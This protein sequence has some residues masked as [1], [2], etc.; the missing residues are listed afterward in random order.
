[1]TT[2]RTTIP[3]ED[4]FLSKHIV[5][6]LFAIFGGACLALILIVFL[7]GNYFTGDITT[8][9]ERWGTFGDFVGGALNPVIG[10][11]GLL[12]LLLTVILQT[13][14]LQYSRSELE[15][16]RGEL[17]ES[18]WHQKKQVFENT[19]FNLIKVYH[20]MRTQVFLTNSANI[21]GKRALK[22]YQSAF[23]STMKALYASEVSL[24]CVSARI[25][26]A[27]ISEFEEELGGLLKNLS[28][29]IE[30]VAKSSFP[31]DE[32]KYYL[33]TLGAQLSIEE[34][35]ILFVYACSRYSREELKTTIEDYGFFSEQQDS[36]PFYTPELRGFYTPSA[37]VDSELATCD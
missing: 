13:R 17:V 33:K 16:T 34:F 11:A 12:A 35:E 24:E 31:H 22:G 5:G 4:T 14:E 28:F 10:L 3:T 32:K 1:M 25:S 8:D 15:L 27:T 18:N 36:F 20:D 19:L 7:Y 30:S 23:D 9:H 21:T 37:F 26:T 6:I 2:S 29:M